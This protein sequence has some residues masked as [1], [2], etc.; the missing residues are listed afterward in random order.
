MTSSRTPKVSR[1]APVDA[2]EQGAVVRDRD[3]SNRM[4]DTGVQRT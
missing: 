4:P 1:T 3:A 2:C